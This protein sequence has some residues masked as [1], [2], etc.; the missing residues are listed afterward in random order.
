MHAY[1]ISGLVGALAA[2]T[3]IGGVLAVH[4]ASGPLVYSRTAAMN[5]FNKSTS[6]P[7]APTS[8][9]AHVPWPRELDHTAYDRALLS[10]ADYPD[11]EAFAEAAAAQAQVSTSSPTSTAPSA[12]P[13]PVPFAGFPPP[14][15]LIYSSSTN[16]TVPGKRWPA[17]APYP[18]GGAI[19]PFNRVVAYYGNFY[20]TRMGILG[21]F[22]SS[23]VLA[24]LASTSAAWEAAD[25]NTPVMP[26]I[27]Y[28]AMVAQGEAGSDGMYRNVMPD[29]HIER[30]YDMTQSIDGI[31]FLDL[32]VGL[33][34]IER[35]LPQFQ[36]YFTRPDVHLAID[37]EFSM[38][39]GNP[40]GT[41]IG[42][43]DTADINF[44]INWLSKIVREH[45]LP[46]KILVVHRFTQNMV[47]NYQDIRPT[48]EVQVVIHMDGWGARDLKRSTY[49]RVVEPEPVQFAGLK[50]FYKN[51]L[52]PPSTG[53]FSPEEA[54]ELHP[55][56]IYIQYQ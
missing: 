19:L 37:P 8:T 26:A 55:E 12:D 39:Q 48:P 29:A 25:P 17:A 46:P 33:S 14:S 52:K 43:F 53:I 15:Q 13:I 24:R 44:A 11:A 23:T 45:E 38:K 50:I 18:H 51:D 5:E 28:I 9:P 1:V 32:Q 20:S 7:R 34:T 49:R 4:H 6:T 35:E 41:V 10:L 54:L 21:E 30:A 16:V 3:L 27:H 42:T 36:P 40:P 47:T 2:S 31:M 22:S 56:P